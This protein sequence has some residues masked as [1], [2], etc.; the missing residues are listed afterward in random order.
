MYIFLPKTT[1]FHH[2][3]LNSLPMPPLPGMPGMPPMPGMVRMPGG[4]MHN[5]MNH[6]RPPQPR[7]SMPDLP[8]SK[9]SLPMGP[10]ISSAAIPRPAPPKPL[11]PSAASVSVL[12]TL[13]HVTL[14][15]RGFMQSARNNVMDINTRI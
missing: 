6:M 10:S 3:V 12:F 15:Q 14:P 7:S 8:V 9:P 1:L 5:Q 13:P 2:V 11:F 4:A